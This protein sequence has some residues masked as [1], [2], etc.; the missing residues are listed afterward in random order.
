[1]KAL[2][3]R[4]VAMLLGVL[5][6]GSAFAADEAAP[7]SNL[8][9]D[10][11]YPGIDYA[12]ATPTNPIAKLQRRIERGEV[13]LENKA[14]RGYLDSLLKAL[15]ID[16]SSQVLIYSKTSLQTDRIEVGTPR[17]VYFN[18]NAYVGSVHDSALIEI[19]TFDPKLGVMFYTLTSE[20]A[21]PPQ[22]ARETGRCLTCHD[23][24]SMLGGGTPRVVVT[25]A[26]VLQ[27]DGSPPPETSGSTTDRSPLAERWGG[28]YVTG[29][30]GNQK[31]LGNLP[32]DDPRKNKPGP[33][34]AAPR[35]LQSLK[36][37][38]DTSTYLTDK[39]DVVALMVLEHQTNVQNQMVRAS[40]KARTALR[41]ITGSDAAPE[42]WQDLPAAQQKQFLPLA[43]PLA[44]AILMEGVAALDEPVSS[45]SGYDQWFQKQ[46]PRDPQGRSLRDL[47][48]K[49][50]VFRY[51]LSYL[52]YSEGFDAM[53]AYFKDYVYTRIEKS[54]SEPGEPAAQLA[55]RRA[56]V[57][58]LLAT[59]PEFAA[60][61]QRPGSPLA[62]DGG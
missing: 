60:H 55:A 44:Q 43:E 7:H 32:L 62:A 27:P 49:H 8:R 28:W 54:V 30:T 42:R 39:S 3:F 51:P 15:D 13:H 9:Y 41:R 48:L 10:F 11:D 16:P 37:L 2:Q 6:G 31:H 34:S 50:S 25:S 58:I 35:N 46:G 20:P 4:P 40:W 38:F 22:F 21:K 56:A 45:S 47:D 59:K 36:G 53:P 23:T 61:A 12:T 5:A 24:Y 1:M 18:D 17:A 52:L 19:A 14:P 29:Q 57:E 26:P 33:L